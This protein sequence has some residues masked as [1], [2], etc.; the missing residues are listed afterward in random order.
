[1]D[2]VDAFLLLR[3]WYRTLPVMY[4]DR[5]TSGR[6]HTPAGSAWHHVGENGMEGV[7]SSAGKAT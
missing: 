2:E 5:S 3:R 4:G 7:H 6:I 1:M